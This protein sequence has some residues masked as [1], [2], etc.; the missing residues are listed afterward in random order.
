MRDTKVSPGEGFLIVTLGSVMV[1]IVAAFF[2]VPL[3]LYYGW[4]LHVCWN[5]IMPGT[6]GL[7]SL[8]LGPAIGVSTVACLLR[9]QV[10]VS[11]TCKVQTKTEKW[12]GLAGSL[13]SPL[14]SI[15]I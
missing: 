3:T 9:G 2:I 13:A 11:K 10:S 5:W 12:A 14:I 7:P 8:G 6:F 4:A 15:L 1:A